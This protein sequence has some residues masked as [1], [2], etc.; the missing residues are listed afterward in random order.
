MG[1]A[2][3]VLREQTLPRLRE[4]FGCDRDA[5]AIEAVLAELDSLRKRLDE[6]E[7]EG[8][9]YR[10][11]IVQAAV[12]LGGVPEAAVALGEGAPPHWVLPAHE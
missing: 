5:D 3:K 7:A 4:L 11:R 6:S 10:A 9:S 12:A 1:D 8:S 2:E